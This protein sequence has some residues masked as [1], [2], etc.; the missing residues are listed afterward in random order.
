MIT[1]T[2]DCIIGI[3]KLDNDHRYLF[4]LMQRAWDL[5]HSEYL[6]DRYT[7]LS[8]ILEELESYAEQHFETEEN[9]MLQIRDPELIQQRTQ[10]N[11]FRDKVH[12][13]NI[14]S[15]AEDDE[16]QQVLEDLISFLAKWLYHHIIG[17]DILIGK[18]PP[19]EEWMLRENPCEF[20]DEFVTGIH[21]IDSEH[22]E[23]FHIID[24]A[25]KMVRTQI[26]ISDLDEILQILARLEEYT[27]EHFQDEEEYMESIGYEGLEAQKRAHAAFI[28]RLDDIH[29]SKAK[30]EEKPQEY[31]QS[32][33]EFLLGWLVN[34][35]LYSDMKIPNETIS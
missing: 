15:I 24:Q 30:M 18:L 20:T 12:E 17:S 26:T 21:L 3:E 27:K 8:S 5:L 31:M 33:V 7:Q 4:E 6:A 11:F 14:T 9:Y 28:S 19:I 23:L 22:K 10:H 32:L 35:I 25:Y 34:H 13:L 2:D 16:Q 1:Y 29:L